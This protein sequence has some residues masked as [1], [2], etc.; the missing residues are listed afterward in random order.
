MSNEDVGH[1]SPSSST[2]T[3]GYSGKNKAQSSKTILDRS[4]RKTNHGKVSGEG[5]TTEED[6][7]NS[8]D[9]A[10][11]DELDDNE[12]DDEEPGSVAPSDG[13]Q[14]GNQDEEDPDS[15]TIGSVSPIG[16]ANN[17]AGQPFDI[18]ALAS[19]SNAKRKRTLSE[20]TS[21]T[22][23]STTELDRDANEYPRKR[24][25]RRL[26]SNANG[27]LRYEGLP[28]AVID[29]DDDDDF[30]LADY[31]EAI[32]S[33]DEEDE[34]T[35]LDQLDDS[36]D[37]DV[38]QLEEAMIIEEE[39]ERLAAGKPDDLSSLGRHT[40]DPLDY[41]D[42]LP[43]DLGSFWSS[44][45]DMFELEHASL[46]PNSHAV[47]DNE[48]DVDFSTPR[49]YMAKRTQSDVSARRVRFE[50]E[51]EVAPSSRASS[52]DTDLNVFP[53]LMDGDTFAAQDNLPISLRDGIEN[54]IDF[55][56]G[57]ASAS[58]TEGSCWDFGE[59]QASKNLFAWHDVDESESD[60]NDSGSDLSGYDCMMTNF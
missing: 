3:D 8:D 51:V 4:A 49:P 25:D 11:S 18:N 37:T 60:G 41:D 2:K 34:T 22:V 48:D 6:E 55:D 57:N 27:V 17:Q 40:N 5:D 32:Q 31:E 16:T 52:A 33:S 20:M 13:A 26:S 36:Q 28:A 53:D 46:F 50:D 10:S 24:F 43:A 58:D 15:D 30:A 47:S 19:A 38:E 39:S 44:E 14:E 1:S 42:E 35:L 56:L 45:L 7:S 9:E 21:N 12:A 23:L 59:E 29:N 54:D